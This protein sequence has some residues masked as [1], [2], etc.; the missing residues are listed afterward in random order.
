[1]E[2]ISDRACSN[3]IKCCWHFHFKWQQFNGSRDLSGTAIESLPVVGLSEIDV[4]KIENTPSMKTIPSIYELQ[5]SGED[6]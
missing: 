1:M 4:L 6:F 2:L 5:V 3:L